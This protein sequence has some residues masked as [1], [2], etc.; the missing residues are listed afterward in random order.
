[1]LNTIAVKKVEDEKVMAVFIKRCIQK[2]E[3][4]DISVLKAVSRRLIL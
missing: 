4:K 3:K 1:V 2:M